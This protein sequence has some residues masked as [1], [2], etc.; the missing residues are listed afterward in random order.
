MAVRDTLLLIALWGCTDKEEVAPVDADQDGFAETEDCDDANAAVYPD[1]PELCGDGVPNACGRTESEA[2]ALCQWSGEVDLRDAPLKVTG[3][4]ADDFVSGARVANLDGD[5]APDLVVGAWGDEAGGT[6]SGTVYVLYGSGSFVPTSAELSAASAELGISGDVAGDR[7][8]SALAVADLDGDGLDDIA[9]GASGADEEAGAVHVFRSSG[10]LASPDDDRWTYEAELTLSG[11]SAGDVAGISLGVVPDVDGD[12]LVELVVG[13]QLGGDDD[14]GSAYLVL[15]AGAGAGTGELGLGAADAVLAGVENKDR[16]GIA[17]AGLDD[18][19]GDGL[20]DLVVGASKGS[21][22]GVETG[23]VYLLLGGGST[24]SLG[25]ADVTVVGVA[26]GD[27]AGAAVADAGD[28]DGDGASDLIV[29]AP[30]ASGDVAGTGAAYV[31]SGGALASAS[32][33]LGL[34]MAAVSLLG[35]TDGDGAGVSVAGDADADGDGL[36]D[37]AV[38]AAGVDGEESSQG[39]AWLLK[40]GGTLAGVAGAFSLSGADAI[41]LGHDEADEAGNPV[42]FAPDLDGDGLDD[43]MVGASGADGAASHAGEIYVMVHP[44][45]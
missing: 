31:V 2:T 17:V 26:D 36:S 1:A 38:G 3:G 44:G 35:T 24:G 39:A 20:G 19:D 42:S 40:S 16:A 6:Q 9:I 43:L 7:A 32:G 18:V 41:F 5:G 33:P 21:P 11:E 34:D 14:A 25:D 22:T 13:A 30:G 10:V 27:L 29:G 4:D 23:A 45:I 8:G 37:L 12:G 15:S 28:V